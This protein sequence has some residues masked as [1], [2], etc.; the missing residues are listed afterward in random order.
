MLSIATLQA[1]TNST[2]ND[3][4]VEL[5]ATW[6]MAH[7][8]TT[9]ATYVDLPQGQFAYTIN[10]SAHEI[11]GIGEENVILQ[12]GSIKTIPQFHKNHSIHVSQLKCIFF[13]LNNWHW[14]K[15]NFDY[16]LLK[17]IFIL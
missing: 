13:L 17:H 12:D 5:G 16:M 2:T 9:F 15:E 14:P 10:G 6:H 1:Q 11:K 8:Q 4:I 3:W 7:T